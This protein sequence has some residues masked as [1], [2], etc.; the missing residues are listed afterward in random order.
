MT[1]GRHSGRLT[2]ILHADV[3]DSTG[4]V[5]KDELLAHDEFQLAFHRFED[6][7]KKYGGRVLELRGDAVIAEFD[8]ASDAVSSALAFQQAT[9]NQT[10]A[11]D[12]SLK[13]TL[14]IGVAMGEVVIADNTVTGA[15]VVLAQRVEQL[16]DPG[17]VCITSAIHEALP[18]RLPF[19]FDNL[20]D[21]DLKGFED[22]VRVFRVMLR[23]GEAIPAPQAISGP[24]L[25]VSWPTAVLAIV[26][27]LTFIAG[28]AYFLKTNGLQQEQ[29]SREPGEKPIVAVLPFENMSGDPQQEYF[30]DGISE[31]IITDLSQLNGL[32][33]IA[34]NS[35]FNFRNTTAT[36]QE[37][38]EKLG[39]QYLL[40]GSV[41]KDGNNIRINAQLVNADSGHQMWA[42]RY[43]RE[44]TDM[45]AVQDEITGKVVSELSVQLTGNE[46][47][48]LAYNSTNN[49]DAYDLFLQGQI[50]GATFSNE[51]V[52]E[53]VNLFRRA[54]EFDPGFARAYGALAIQLTRQVLFG[55]TDKPEQTRALALEMVLSGVSLNPDSP[56]VQWALGYVYLYREE[57]EKAIAAL[58][59][60][61]SLSPSYADG[62]AMLALIKNNL[63]QAEEAIRLLEKGMELNPF[64]SWDYL[65]NLGRAHYTL[66]NYQQAAGFLEQALQ[67]NASPRAPRMFLIATYVQLGRQDDAEWEV[68]QL[69]IS[70][71]ET[72]LSQLRQV[73]VIKDDELFQRLLDD[74]E[75][76]GLAE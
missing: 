2:V 59:R 74:L 41:R 73:Y 72:T 19:D 5:Q 69:E 51:G 24:G 11:P 15:G 48:Q 17:G 39:A 61:V 66:G 46:R 13:P 65:Y 70:S 47:R 35:S 33:V 76:A 20:G 62:Y 40:L 14:R 21:Q 43:D 54:I 30:S 16:A 75:A 31:D 7:I 38:A 68:M 28:L 42:S 4:L 53:A 34:R 22:T 57:F 45:F 27:T 52:S 12:D 55:Y 6:T 71:P 60:A 26:L 64:Y 36:V 29:V 37:I 63:G 10:A 1:K 25:R 9:A 50:A 44:L 58:E 3:A 67:R 18:R 56:Q 49:F 32:G 23:S 8:R